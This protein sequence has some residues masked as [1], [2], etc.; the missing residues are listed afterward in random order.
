M[1]RSPGRRSSPGPARIVVCNAR[2]SAAAARG[3]G[4]TFSGGES[5]LRGVARPVSINNPPQARGPRLAS[6]IV[7]LVIPPVPRRAQHTRPVRSACPAGP[8]SAQHTRPVRFACPAGPRSA[9]HVA[10]V[11][12]VLTFPDCHF[13]GGAL[14]A[15]RVPWVPWVPGGCRKHR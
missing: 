6:S 9:Q 11:R 2:A 8:R 7:R 14:G 12:L 3:G 15:G 1:S 4:R 10:V 5:F 13:S